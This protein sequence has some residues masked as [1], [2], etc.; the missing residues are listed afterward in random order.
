M[1]ILLITTSLPHLR[2]NGA[3][4]ATM[5]LIAAI[6][7]AGHTCEVVGYGRA[8][9]TDALPAGFHSAG[10]WPIEVENAGARAY[11]WMIAALLTG[12]PYITTK[13][14][15]AAM[16]RLLR[17]MLAAKSYDAVI[18]NHAH[19]AWVLDEPLLPRRRIAVAHNVEWQL[20][21]AMGADPKAS[22]VR[23]FVYGR[24]ARLV[25]ALETRLATTSAQIWT[26]TEADADGFRALGAR[27]APIVLGIPGQA[28]AALDRPAVP[29]L[30]IGILGNWAWDVNRKGLEWFIEAVVPLLPPSLSIGIAGNRADLVPNPYGNVRYFG[31]VPD[32]GAFL[33]DCRVLAVPT[34]VGGGI[35]I[36]TIEG[37][38][39]GVPMVT[40]P[41]G[42]RGI[43]EVPDFV[44]VEPSAEGFAARLS[45]IAQGP[46]C[47]DTSEGSRWAEAR[48]A[49]FQRS[50]RAA[51]D[52]LAAKGPA[53]IAG[54]T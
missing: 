48:A 21:A 51:L 26:L 4:T 52:A 6:L 11:V 28:F 16:T 32:A 17:R 42:L 34:Q 49:G 14:R 24:E 18:V 5:N 19:M 1:R 35:Q 41:L 29:R 33:R 7:A 46:N 40:T 9:E 3:E 8:G 20:Y 12:K 25:K 54:T 2:K 10:T 30:D 39:A 31:F 45:A 36:K 53:Q 23:R 50:M 38:S 44:H 37:I 43:T 15:S 47:V 27:S 13:F 22:P